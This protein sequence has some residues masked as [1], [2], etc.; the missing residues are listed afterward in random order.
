MTSRSPW[1]PGALPDMSLGKTD[2]LPPVVAAWAGN[3]AFLGLGAWLLF[4][5]E[6]TA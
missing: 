5:A 4:R 2:V 3:V 6:R 1:K